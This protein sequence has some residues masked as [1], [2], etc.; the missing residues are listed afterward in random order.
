[1]NIA[2]R[3][4]KIEGEESRRKILRIR[5]GATIFFGFHARL[6]A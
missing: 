6:A 5:G 2:A 1:M 3:I 4:G